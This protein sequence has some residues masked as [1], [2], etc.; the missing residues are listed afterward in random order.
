MDFLFGM[1]GVYD[2]ITFY[3]AEKK[4]SSTLCMVFLYFEEVS[5]LG[6]NVMKHKIIPVKH[7]SRV[8]GRLANAW[9]VA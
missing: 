2:W 3:G 1:E 5:A 4:Q 8:G 6:I 9:V 7:I